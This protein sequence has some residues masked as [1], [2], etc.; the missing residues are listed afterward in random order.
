MSKSPV[1]KRKPLV[2]Y[3]ISPKPRL[4]TVP[5]GRIEAT[6]S[7][8]NIDLDIEP[9]NTTRKLPSEEKKREFAVNKSNSGG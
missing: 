1:Q 2:S 5:L 3:P 7:K 4:R 8:K 6:P 9:T